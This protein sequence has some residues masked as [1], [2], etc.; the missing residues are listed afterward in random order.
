VRATDGE[1]EVQELEEDR[2]FTS[3]I[4]GFHKILVHIFA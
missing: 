3:G 4:T 1:G 2:E